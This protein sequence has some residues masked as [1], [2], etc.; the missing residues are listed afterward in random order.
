MKNNYIP[1]MFKEK[2]YQ[3]L[4]YIYAFFLLL[5]SILSLLSLLT[6]DIN[7][8]SFLTNSSYETQNFLGHFGSYYASFI[9]YTFGIFAYLIILCGGL[10]NMLLKYPNIT[11]YCKL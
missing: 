10:H 3:S 4:K 1:V 11:I 5:L 7:D 8:N 9:F 2:I 6:F